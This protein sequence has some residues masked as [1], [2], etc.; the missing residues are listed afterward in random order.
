MHRFD[1]VS[2]MPATEHTSAEDFLKKNFDGNKNLAVWDGELYLEMH[3][4]T[5]TT[6]SVLKR[7]NRK[8]ESLVRAAEILSVVRMLGEKKNYPQK[9]KKK[10]NLL[11]ILERKNLSVII[12]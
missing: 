1:K 10:T 8:L 6:K 2:V 5:F 9:S 4:G 12:K 11:I 3:R 7:Y